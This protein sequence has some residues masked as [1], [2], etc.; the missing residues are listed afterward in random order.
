MDGSR[1]MSYTEAIQTALAEGAT[2]IAHINAAVYKLYRPVG[3]AWE[4]RW[5]A[6]NQHNGN[7]VL[8]AWQG[9]AALAENAE[10]I[11]LF[12]QGPAEVETA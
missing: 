8:G 2:R 5:Y 10:E 1:E 6:M 12:R 11:R 4:W 9:P 7:W 3:E